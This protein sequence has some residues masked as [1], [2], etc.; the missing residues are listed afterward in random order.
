LIRSHRAIT[1]EGERT[2]SR[3]DVKRREMQKVKRRKCEWKKE[4]KEKDVKRKGEGTV[5]V[6]EEKPKEYEAVEE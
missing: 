5:V 6:E 4:Q 3:K 2:R 1:Y